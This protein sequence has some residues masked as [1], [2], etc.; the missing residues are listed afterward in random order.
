MRRLR[1]VKIVATLGPASGSEAGI[2]ELARA[3]ADVFRINMS[4]TSHD[5]LARMVKDLRALADAVGRPIGVLVDLQG[6][7]SGARPAILGHRAAPVQ[8]SY[9]GLPGTS[10]LPGFAPNPILANGA[11]VD[12]PEVFFTYSE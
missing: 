8:V 10:A 5:L 9:L 3:G 6:L 11:V 2:E 4:H 12:L 1:R 7:T